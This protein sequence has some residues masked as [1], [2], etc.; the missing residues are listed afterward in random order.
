MCSKYTLP[1]ILDLAN[2]IDAT[3]Q[4]CYIWSADL[5]R[6]YRQM[7][8]CPL[9]APLNAIMVH[10]LTYI[11]VTPS[12]GCRTS[13]AACA[14]MTNSVVWL[15]ANKGHKVLCY[16]D[17][18]VGIHM[19]KHQAEQAYS[20]FLHISDQLGLA[21][22]K[23]KCRAPTHSLQWLGFDVHTINMTVTIPQDRLDEALQ[24]CDGWKTKK[25]AS[26][27]QLQRL[28]GKLQHITKCVIPGRRFMSRIRKALRDTPYGGTH[29]LPDGF[30]SD[31]KWFVD[32]ATLHNGIALIP[33]P[34]LEPW[35]VECDSSKLEAGAHSPTHYY[36]Y[37]YTAVQKNLMQNIASL[38]AVNLIN[39]L[40]NLMPPH[41]Q[42][43]SITVNTDNTA[44]QIV[45][46]SGKG[47]DPILTA[48][49]RQVWFLAA[50]FST[51]I[52]VIHKPGIQ[53]VLADSLS[54]SH[55]SSKA[56]TKA[57]SMCKTLALKEI[58]IDFVTD[59]IL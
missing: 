54:R 19:N 30:Y 58:K 23:D 43:F 59:F 17:D 14:R 33:P 25:T 49:A 55:Q 5:S 1:G 10:G 12:F 52:K 3:G 34:L 18:F 46:D 44:S 29:P 8:L 6:A 39:A 48:C 51:S 7:R 31:V 41:P 15:M 50:K 38:E 20:D 13:S 28:I 47:Q 57:R 4:G 21:L 2:L 32:Y 36:S 26:R 45:L 42:R 40:M 11:D 53:L 16:L 37:K 22:N 35:V 56:K 9:S 27:K 24:Q